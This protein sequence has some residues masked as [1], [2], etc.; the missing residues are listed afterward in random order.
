MR[1]DREGDGEEIGW[2]V[3]GFKGLMR[4][5]HV[6]RGRVGKGGVER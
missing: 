4:K 3:T 2:R 6:E 1:R 5:G